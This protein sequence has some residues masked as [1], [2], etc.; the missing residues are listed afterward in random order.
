MPPRRPL[1]RAQLHAGLAAALALLAG[2][3]PAAAAP[4]RPWMNAALSPDRPADLLTKAM[5]QDEKFRLIRAEYGAIFNGQPKPPGSKDSAGYIPQ[6]TWSH[7][8][9]H[10]DGQ[11]VEFFFNGVLDTTRTAALGPVRRRPERRLV[12]GRR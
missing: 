10:Y 8:A 6:R 3:A 1:Q 9:V 2:T 5:T 7:V 12:P 11:Q 4:G